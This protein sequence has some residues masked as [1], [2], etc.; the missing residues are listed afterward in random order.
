MF[1]SVGGNGFDIQ[2]ELAPRFGVGLFIR[3]S[4]PRGGSR[5]GLLRTRKRT[6]EAEL[7]MASRS[8][9]CSPSEQTARGGG[10]RYSDGRWLSCSSGSAP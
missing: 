3:W 10:S 2:P 4:A 7:H 9:F 6:A 1:C 5:E 8:N